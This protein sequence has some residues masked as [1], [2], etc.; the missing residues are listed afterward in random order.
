MPHKKRK[1]VGRRG[2]FNLL[3]FSPATP[4]LRTYITG[5]A[6]YAQ[7]RLEREQEP[8]VNAAP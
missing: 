3:A 2:A 4:G 8:D 6:V 5:C 1:A 7:D